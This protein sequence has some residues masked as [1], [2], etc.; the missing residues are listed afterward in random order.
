MS[1]DE[2]LKIYTELLPDLKKWGEIVDSYIIEI[3]KDR[4]YKYGD[5]QIIPKY[6]SKSAISFID[7]ALY[8]GKGYNNPILEI[9][10]KIGTR[11]VTLTTEIV[12]TLSKDL[13]A[14][15]N[16]KI[17]ETKSKHEIFYD[18]PDK[19]GYQSIHYIATPLNNNGIFVSD[20][21]NLL[22]CEIQVR[23]LLQHA[24]AEVSHDNVYKGP[25]KNDSKILRNLARSMALMESADDYFCRIC[26]EVINPQNIKAMLL[27]YLVEKFEEI[28][29]YK[30]G[31][32]FDRN[33]AEDILSL[34]HFIPVEIEE[35]N[36]F[37]NSNQDVINAIK[38]GKS[39]I[40]Q[41]PI[42][43]LLAYY[44]YNKPYSLDDFWNIDEAIYKSLK[45]SLGYSIEA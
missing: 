6:R 29:G 27:K 33:L 25:F 11:I 45:M 15:P 39:M 10:D 34:T 3:I 2:L 19:F 22:T 21:T 9:E 14:F 43:I 4:K 42:I 18:C 31:Y 20:N 5:I 35:I 37:I 30:D 44:I 8:R 36:K 32:T 40:S 7:K 26:K 1:E 28:K 17:K 41:Q 12:D 38:Y 16:W 24:Y 13:I 23:T